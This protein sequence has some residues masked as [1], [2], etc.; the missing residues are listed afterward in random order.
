MAYFLVWA[1]IATV[2]V[3]HADVFLQ[4]L[5]IYFPLNASSVQRFDIY[6]NKGGGVRTRTKLTKQ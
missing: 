2:P 5:C 1:N 3:K 4:I 6:K